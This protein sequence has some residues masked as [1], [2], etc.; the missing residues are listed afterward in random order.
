MGRNNHGL[1]ENAM[2]TFPA[3]AKANTRQSRQ[4]I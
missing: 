1:L 4:G 2:P 3:Y